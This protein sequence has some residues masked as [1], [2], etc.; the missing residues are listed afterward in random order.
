[1]LRMNTLILIFGLSFSYAPGACF[2]SDSLLPCKQTFFYNPEPDG[3]VYKG[4]ELWRL[5]DGQLVPFRDIGSAYPEA[6]NRHAIE[7]CAKKQ[8]LVDASK[9]PANK[10]KLSS[11]P[12]ASQISISEESAAK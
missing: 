8:N 1:M 11:T 4:I 7:L 2:A 6:Y 3:S 5:E 9:G 10:S 12:V